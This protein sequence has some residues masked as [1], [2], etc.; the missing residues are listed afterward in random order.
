MSLN[1]R[2]GDCTVRSW[3]LDADD[4]EL[5]GNTTEPTV[6]SW[7]DFL[8]IMRVARAVRRTYDLFDVPQPD[9]TCR[10]YRA[11]DV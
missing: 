6:L 9:G 5:P 1:Q 8:D 4:V 3:L 10:R 11:I 2:T 7:V